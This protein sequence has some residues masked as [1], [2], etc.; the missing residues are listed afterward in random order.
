MNCYTFDRIIFMKQL[1]VFIIVIWTFLTGIILVST[2]SAIGLLC[3]ENC[4][5]AKKVAWVTGGNPEKVYAQLKFLE[6]EEQKE[7]FTDNEINHLI[8]VSRWLL[9]VKM[10]WII[11]SLGILM[12]GRTIDKKSIYQAGVT[13]G[14][15]VMASVILALLGWSGF[16]ITFHKIF[17]PQGNWS[18][19]SESLLISLYPERFWQR[20]FITISVLCVGIYSIFLL[21]IKG[22]KRK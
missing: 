22:M 4:E 11:C 10:V 8:D 13:G 18:F 14:V 3:S 17:F 5:V 19:P 7:L 20:M 21:K 6:L 9:V 2:P 12:S 16:F 15:I 1:V